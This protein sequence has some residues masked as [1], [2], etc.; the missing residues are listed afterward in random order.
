MSKARLLFALTLALGT[1]LYFSSGFAISQTPHNINAEQAKEDSSPSSC[2]VF[3]IGNRELLAHDKD[4][5][6][7]SAP[8]ISQKTNTIVSIPDNKRLRMTN[9]T[10]GRKLDL[11]FSH[12]IT[13][14]QF[15]KDG[16]WSYVQTESGEGAFVN[17]ATGSKQKARTHNN[18]T[19]TELEATITAQFPD[20][21]D[22]SKIGQTPEGIAALTRTPGMVF[23]HNSTQALSIS[24]DGSV[25]V[26]DLNSGAA[27]ATLEIK[28]NYS[29]A[30]FTNNETHVVLISATNKKASFYNLETKKND[31]EV[32]FEGPPLGGISDRATSLDNAALQFVVLNGKND[33][34]LVTLTKDKKFTFNIKDN[35]LETYPIS[36]ND[37][38]ISIIK[39]TKKASTEDNSAN[40]TSTKYGSELWS[41]K[42]GEV[43]VKID[44]DYKSVIPIPGQGKAIAFSGADI[45]PHRRV[46]LHDYKTKD[47]TKAVYKGAVT[48]DNST[49]LAIAYE[50]DGKIHFVDAAN[51]KT[52]LLAPD[53]RFNNALLSHYDNKT[54]KAIFLD[55]TT[56]QRFLLDL[57]TQHLENIPLHLSA[58][59]ITLN[60]NQNGQSEVFYNEH[61]QAKIYNPQSKKVISVGAQSIRNAKTVSKNGG[62]IFYDHKTAWSHSPNKRA[63]LHVPKIGDTANKQVIPYKDKLIDLCKK[64]FV[65]DEWNSILPAIPADPLSKE[66]AL[67]YLLKFQKKDGFIAERDAGTLAAVVEHFKEDKPD[68]V[69]SALENVLLSSNQLYERFIRTLLNPYK[70]MP[71]SSKEFSCRTKNEDDAI[72]QQAQNYLSLLVQTHPDTAETAS[73]ELLWPLQHRFKSLSKQEKENHLYN[74]AKALAN[75]AVADPQFAGLFASKIYKLAYQRMSPLF[76]LPSIPM[77]DLSLAREESGLKPFLLGTGTLI[78]PSLKTGPTHSMPSKYGFNYIALDPVSIPQ[79]TKPGNVDLSVLENTSWIH[80]GKRYS[81]DVSVDVL[82]F[83]NKSIVF[84]NKAPPYEELWK[85]GSLT[86][87]VI[88]GTN[89]L[90]DAKGTIDEY[91]S[92]YQNNGFN[93]SSEQT[94]TSLH[95]LVKD[96]VKGGELD[97][98]IKEAHSDGDEKNLFRMDRTAAYI[99]GEKTL[100]NGKKERVYLVYPNQKTKE[101][102]LLANDEFG[103]WIQ[104]R[105]AKGLGPLVYFNTSC[106][107]H[108]KALFEIEA[109]ASDRL[110][111]IPTLNMARMFRNYTGNAEYQLFTA[112]R[113]GKNWEDIRKAMEK[114][115]AYKYKKENVFMFPDED[116]YQ[117]KILDM[118][119]TPLKIRVKTKDEK[120]IPYNIDEFQ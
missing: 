28:D 88:A 61:G 93:F 80:E 66:E 31:R 45:E 82:D 90:D 9:G 35:S 84:K 91:L 48:S 15:S 62:A 74:M 78:S 117:S 51:N 96:K 77:T 81:A 50:L 119:K 16:V 112:F 63:C 46:Y 116:T 85:D 95:T 52:T 6:E 106:W 69:F 111:N 118:I 75:G 99:V 13:N 47:Q 68:A 22:Y 19:D 110:L 43:L 76:S 21:E 30:T 8:Y 56:Y 23:N 89:L 44:D 33:Y 17:L 34:S 54:Q 18:K 20:P 2:T 27:K 102:T 113:E 109:A 38:Y 39:V 57:K 65:E 79:G 55:T 42:T 86:G 1:H 114:N 29:Q 98:F 12:P 97:Y 25:Q 70:P 37:D 53:P 107:S 100:E 115:E 92:Y 108:T 59:D 64:D 83:K 67:F 36:A 26:F 41:G 49:F 103:A 32:L 104:E 71:S 87:M 5:A 4:V 72:T 10:T 120:G 73:F 3:H 24:D 58:T 60:T 14:V 11:E 105:E 94:T 101:T 7:M 40:D